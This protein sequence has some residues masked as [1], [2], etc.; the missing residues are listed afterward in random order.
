MQRKKGLVKR[1]SV[2]F[3]IKTLPSCFA[4]DPEPVPLERFPKASEIA[5]LGALQARFSSSSLD[6]IVV[7][8]QLGAGSRGAVMAISEIVFAALERLRTEV[9]SWGFAGTGTRFVKFFQPTAAS[10]FQETFAEAAQVHSLT[11]VCPTLALHV[12]FDIPDRSS[13]E[14]MQRLGIAYGVKAGCINPPEAFLR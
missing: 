10:A 5:E 11:G 14:V 12:Q 6:C 2:S 9:P 13:I 7:R 4:L 1:R 3:T 8:L